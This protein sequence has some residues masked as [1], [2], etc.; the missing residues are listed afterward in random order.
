MV[1]LSIINYKI[2]QHLKRLVTFYVNPTAVPKNS[3][4]VLIYHLDISMLYYYYVSNTSFTFQA[5]TFIL[6]AITTI[7]FA[8][9]L[10]V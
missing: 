8:P 2:M 4:K 1:C 6:T 7:C 3:L 5:A 10:S 9:K